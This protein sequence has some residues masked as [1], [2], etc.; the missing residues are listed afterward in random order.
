M[1]RKS[2]AEWVGYPPS[3]RVQRDSLPSILAGNGENEGNRCSIQL[4]MGQSQSLF[5]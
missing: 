5:W 1:S 3:S 4:T 2:T